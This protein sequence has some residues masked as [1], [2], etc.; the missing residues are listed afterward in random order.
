[1]TNTDTANF[2]LEID[3]GVSGFKVKV[4]KGNLKRIISIQDVM[5]LLKN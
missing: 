3:A 4:E 2:I 1:M 5:S